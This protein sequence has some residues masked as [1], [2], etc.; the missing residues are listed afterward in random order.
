MH[1]KYRER[2]KEKIQS[3]WKVTFKKF[4]LQNFRASSRM[5]S[6]VFFFLPFLQVPWKRIKEHMLRKSWDQRAKS[7]EML[8]D[9]RWAARSGRIRRFF[10]AHYSNRGDGV[11]IAGLLMHARECLDRVWKLWTVSRFVILC[12]TGLLS[13]QGNHRVWSYNKTSRPVK[14]DA[15]WC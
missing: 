2:E 15:K 8:S 6:K 7:S 1:W 3:K 11:C 10:C 5:D 9:D 4:C 12:I 13:C 14:L